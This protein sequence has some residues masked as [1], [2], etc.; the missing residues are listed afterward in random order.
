MWRLLGVIPA[1][2][3]PKGAHVAPCGSNSAPNGP[4]GA[5][6]SQLGQSIKEFY[7]EIAVPGLTEPSRF[8]AMP[9]P[10]ALANTAIYRTWCL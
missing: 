8:F 1:H 4:R 5:P 3:G 9:A 7:S 2:K 10:V 6:R